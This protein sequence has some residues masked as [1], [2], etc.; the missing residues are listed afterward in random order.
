M[1]KA[2]AH[3]IAME[4]LKKVDTAKPYRADYRWKILFH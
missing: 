1:K 3:D 4:M 2:D